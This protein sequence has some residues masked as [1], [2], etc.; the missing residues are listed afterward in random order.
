MDSQKTDEKSGLVVPVLLL[1]IG[2]G[3]LLTN[4][5]FVPKVE[6]AWS[7]GL[8]AGGAL[9]LV[10]RGIN[11]GS[12]VI[13][14]FLIFCGLLSIVRQAGMIDWEVEFPCLVIAM[15]ALLLIAKISNLP[16]GVEGE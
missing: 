4:L 12:I 14:P 11:K 8:I 9:M 2:V 16:S 5:G 15:G 1:T 7:L 3:W 13:G 6:W 10:I